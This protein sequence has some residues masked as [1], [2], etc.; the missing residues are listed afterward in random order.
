MKQQKELCPSASVAE[1]QA[2][3]FINYYQSNGW[4][5]GR[6]P[7]QHWQAAARNWLLNLQDYEKTQRSYAPKSFSNPSQESTERPMDYSIPL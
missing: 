1:A 5:V 7:M 2:Q 3:R 6:H 4:K